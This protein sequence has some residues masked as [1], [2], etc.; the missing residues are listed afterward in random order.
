[1]ARPK[2]IVQLYPVIP[3]DGEDDRRAR[4]PIGADPEIYQRIVHEWTEIVQ[5]A[6]RMGIWGM[7]T[8]EH[9]LH[10]EGY[11]VGPNPG[12]LNAH[13]ANFTTNTRVG[14]LGYVMSTRDPIR[15]AEETAILDHLSNGRFFV[16]FSRGYQTR[17]TNILGQDV[18][19]QGTVS[20]GSGADAHNREVFEERVEMV[21]KCWTEESTVLDGKYYQAPYPLK[22]GVENYPAWEIARDAGV[23]GEVDD[24]GNTRRICV[25]PKP[26]Q[27]PYPPVFMA[28]AKS[29]ETIDFAAKHG[30]YP[31][32]FAPNQ[33]VAELAQVY[34]DECAKYGRN[35][36]YGQHQNIVRH[37]R[38]A[39]S[40]EAFE[41]RLRKYD[42]DIF[43]NFY[44][45]FANHNVDPSQGDA[46][47]AFRDMVDT[48][49]YTGGTLDDCIRYWQETT[50]LVP[51]E[52]ITLIWHW[53]QQP[54]D[55]LLEEMRLFMEKVVPELDVPD[56]AMAAE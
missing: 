12:I 48:G 40:R 50:A 49:F 39:P 19:V 23:E 21:L 56:Y 55:A 1:V 42:F 17:W 31:T 29:R 15:V 13:W 20:D 37:T 7:S 11:E 44:S 51:C 34:V 6:D 53:A 10:S 33:A 14:A 18:D 36:A 3:A 5:E 26:W 9:H 41:E 54:K 47:K 16:G 32:Y 27:K 25:V 43:R 24:K 46:E 2:I 52:Y 35:V 38:I 8:I 4:R 22:T 28:V 45:A 30:F